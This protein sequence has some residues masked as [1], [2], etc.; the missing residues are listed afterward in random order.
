MVGR[1]GVQTH[2]VDQSVMLVCT[3]AADFDPADNVLWE[4]EANR[5]AVRPEVLCIGCQS[6]MAMSNDAYGKYVQLDKK[7]KV[8]CVQCVSELMTKDSV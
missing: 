1:L 7:P 3:R 6:P 5:S 2:E 8:C 4:L